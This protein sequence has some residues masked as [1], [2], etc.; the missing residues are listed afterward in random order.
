VIS[1]IDSGRSLIVSDPS[2]DDGGLLG[3]GVFDRLRIVLVV[4]F[5]E[6]EVV[7][8]LCD[9]DD[10]DISVVLDLLGQTAGGPWIKLT[11]REDDV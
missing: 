11:I 10:V 7:S 6:V 4:G 5:P 9:I 1:L 3:S 8:G 2:L